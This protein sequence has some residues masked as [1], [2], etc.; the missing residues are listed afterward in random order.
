MQ[1]LV[2]LGT[3]VLA[4]ELF[5]L[6]DE[7][8]GFEVAAFIENLD[9]ER[10]SQT[11]EGLPILWIDELDALCETHLAVSGISTTNRWSYIEEAASHGARFATLVHPLARVSRR[12]T[13]GPGCFIGPGCIV[14][15]HATLGAHVFLNRGATVG[16]H[17]RIDDCVTLQPRANVAGLVH[18]EQRT[19]IGMSA[20]VIER[21]HIGAGC[22]VGAGSLVVKDLPAHVQAMGVP[23]RITKENIEYK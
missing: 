12:A 23:A 6:I 14:S 10:C 2:I 7:I 5:D 1:P 9:R 17:T 19:Y 4:E 16:H 8:P 3:G 15:T 21:R 13:L 18:I 22:L 11:L 20:T